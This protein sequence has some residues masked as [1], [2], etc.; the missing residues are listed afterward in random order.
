MAQRGRPRKQV[1]K[2]NGTEDTKDTKD[3]EMVE[4]TTRVKPKPE[5]TKAKIPDPLN[6]DNVDDNFLPKKAS[7]RVDEAAEY[8]DVSAG[9]IRTWIDHGHLKAEKVV[10][11]IRIT[12]KSILKCRFAKTVQGR[13]EQQERRQQ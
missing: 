9:T 11:S 10:G 5:D 8:F 2:T 3:T 13:V 6:P 4:D 7:I 12:R 1:A